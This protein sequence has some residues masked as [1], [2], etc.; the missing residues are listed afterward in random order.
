MFHF[1]IPFYL[2]SGPRLF[3]SSTFKAR[4][5][6]VWN[7]LLRTPKLNFLPGVYSPAHVHAPAIPEMFSVPPS[8]RA[9]FVPLVIE[10]EKTQSTGKKQRPP[11]TSP[12]LTVSCASSGSCRRP[13]LKGHREEISRTE[14]KPPSRVAQCKV[15]ASTA[16]PH[17]N[18]WGVENKLQPT[19]WTLI[20]GG[21]CAT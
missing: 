5:A 14:M 19:I 6:K 1:K 18:W 17:S 11:L 8:E 7:L 3:L 12:V 9:F 16:R 15:K 10:G 2:L 4:S 13:R 21:P 20:P